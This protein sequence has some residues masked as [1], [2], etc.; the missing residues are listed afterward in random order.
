MVN[1]T[2]ANS[3]N[4][5]GPMISVGDLGVVT[6]K[7]IGTFTCRQSEFTSW[8]K[9]HRQL[10]RA[11][12][13]IEGSELPYRI[14]ITDN[15]SLTG[16]LDDGRAISVGN[17][18]PI[19]INDIVEMVPMNCAIC[20]GSTHS[21]H[22]IEARYTLT[23]LFEGTF[24]VHHDGW[25]ALLQ[26]NEYALSAQKISQGLKLSLEGL[27]LQI[28]GSGKSEEDY[29]SC[30]KDIMLLLSLANGNGVSSHRW[31][32]S[33]PNQ[34]VVEKWRSRAG[35]EIGPG[36]IV[37]HW[38]LEQFLQ[39]CLPVLRQMSQEDRALIGLAVAYINSSG[40]GYLDTRLIL[41][42]QAWEFLAAKWAPI[43]MLTEPEKILRDTIKRCYKEWRKAHPSSD[44]DGAWGNRVLFAFEWPK[45]KR[46]IE[47]LA[48]Q[49][50]LDLEIV[51][52]NLE[53][54]KAAR[55]SVAHQGNL[56]RVDPPVIPHHEL[57]MNAQ[58]GLQLLLLQKLG[59][60]GDVKVIENGWRSDKP[61]S[62]FFK[63]SGPPKLLRGRTEQTDHEND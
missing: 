57:L 10:S 44:P 9:L 15:L 60:T 18:H 54:L 26:E 45:L 22:P 37:E 2:R 24:V 31:S 3:S 5:N 20:I 36:C 34:E 58:Q 29:E 40:T 27:A 23:G 32:L 33:Y 63:S 51:G 12:L 46:Q 49:A 6:L 42:A 41:T 61:I 48:D 28:S 7:G 47:A 39:Q 8:F 59:Y 55:D 13:V 17:L 21:A 62:H 16:R 11:V 43:G 38:C 30:A 50:A 25:T 35:D 19:Q 4:Q 14:N 56:G 1:A 53:Q 52:I